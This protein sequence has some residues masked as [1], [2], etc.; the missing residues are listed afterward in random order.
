M[1]NGVFDFNKPIE[2]KKKTR[3]IAIGDIHGDYDIF[4]ELLKLAKVIDSK[5]NWIGKRTIVI[6]MGD[7]LDGKRPDVIASNDFINK[8]MEIRIIN[9]IK[10][11]NKKAFKY[12][13]SVVSILGNH[14]LYSYY[15]YNDNMFNKEY[16]KQIDLDDYKNKF[17]MKRKDYYYPGKGDGAKNFGK[18]RPMIIQI[19]E[20]LFSHGTISKNFVKLYTNNLTKKI[21][22]QQINDE[23]SKWLMGKGIKPKFID[24]E[25]EF[26]PLFDRSLSD[27]IN[28]SPM[29]CHEKFYSI[30]KFFYNAK[31]M[32]MGHSVHKKINSLCDNK[33]FRVDIAISR[34]FGGTLENNIKKMQVLE[35][36]QEPNK[37]TIF[38]IIK[39]S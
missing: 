31:Y 39:K 23:M 10:I 20:V 14:E 4:I 37:K 34:A 26:N 36:I 22:I 38:N 11:L 16:V 6:Q 35:I 2:I 13:G 3:I 33:V 15:Y 28:M 30:L 5:L 18:T 19:G 32:I 29:K 25:E 24:M 12:G 9:L 21:N 27:P 17:K 1:S 7:L 8:A